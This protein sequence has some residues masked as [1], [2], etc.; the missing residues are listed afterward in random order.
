[1][2]RYIDVD[3]LSKEVLASWDK[4]NHKTIEA[5]H[6]HRQEHHHLMRIIE[7]Q[8]IADV[9]PKS[10]VET[11]RHDIERIIDEGEYWQGKYLVAKQEVAREIFEDMQSCLIQRHWNG[12]DIVS[13]EFDAVKYAELK[14]KYTESED[15]K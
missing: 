13:F 6:I 7:K 11:L 3:K 1:M 10:E 2:A 14:K 9:V 4:D 12:L 15:T 5:S 8:P